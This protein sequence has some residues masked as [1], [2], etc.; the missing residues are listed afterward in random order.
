MIRV[1]KNGAL[2]YISSPFLFPLHGIPEDYFR[3]TKFFYQKIFQS[4]EVLVISD[5]CFKPSTLFVIFNLFLETS[6]PYR[7]RHIFIPI[8]IIFNLSALISESIFRRIYKI[9]PAKYKYYFD[10]M[11]IGYSLVVRIK[12]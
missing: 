9:T 5:A 2:V 11:P 6:I 1:S 8:K 7:F 10:S 3:L 4:H 12:K